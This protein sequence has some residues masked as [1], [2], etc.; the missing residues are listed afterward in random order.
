MT[1]FHLHIKLMNI[2]NN[3][4]GKVNFN[5]IH[6]FFFFQYDL[7]CFLCLVRLDVLSSFGRLGC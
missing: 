2:I 3:K 6:V 5:A 1:K 7:Y 4:S